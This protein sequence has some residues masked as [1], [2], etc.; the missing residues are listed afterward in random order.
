MTPATPPPSPAIAVERQVAPAARPDPL[1]A[2]QGFLAQI[3]WTP[4]DPA[5]R[6]PL[7]AVLDTG[8]DASDPDLA[9]VV[10]T[11]AVRSFVPGIA[12]GAA[13]PEG[14]GTHVAAIIGARAGNGVGGAGVAAARILPV[15]I[16][17]GDG[18]TTPS[19]LVQ[20]LRYASARGARVINIS[21]GG[22]GYSRA[23]QDAIDAA[24]R[25]GA[26][27]VVAAGNDGG[28]SGGPE[29]PGAY[30]QVLTVGAVGRTGRALALSER[31]PQVAIAAPGK[32]IA[33]VPPRALPGI[34]AVG[35]V[36]KTGTS[37][38]A[39]IVSGAAARLFALHPRWS[40]QQVRAA[41]LVTARDVPPAGP[42]V[43]TGAGVLDLAA[44]LAAPAPPPEDPEPNDDTVLAQ[45]TPAI[46]TATRASAVVPGRTGSLSDP[47]DGFRVELRA[48]E[49]LTAQLRATGTTGAD[50]D[51]ALWLPG[52]P[53]GRRG[54]AFG[55]TW[56]AASSLGP[57][58]DERIDVV[59]PT[60]GMFTLEVQGLRGES[61]YV[62]SVQRGATSAVQAFRRT[63]GQSR[64]GSG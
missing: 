14:H 51:L 22:R 37:M 42:D 45:G 15:T 28:A 61:P 50:L 27:I 64:M 21:F 6:R 35:L 25:A 52:T 24:V 34:A 36:R 26:L 49:R 23:E 2:Q 56:L 20:G 19:A 11:G 43:S 32:G 13:D 33:S 1:L 60:T 53:A 39:A 41:L 54:P 12:G 4:P 47:R 46:L 63:A 8:I 9:G 59:A 16:A 10:L 40:A 18:N 58:A 7:V 44:A 48:G 29:Y 38:A 55:R 62:L 5:G 3:G 31:G 30:R 17:D 57:T